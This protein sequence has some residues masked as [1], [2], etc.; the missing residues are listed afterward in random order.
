MNIKTERPQLSMGTLASLSGDFF[1][2]PEVVIGRL[3]RWGYEVVSQEVD[4][5]G[6]VHIQFC[7][8]E[9]LANTPL[10]QRKQIW[11]GND[12][13]DYPDKAS[14][15]RANSLMYIGKDGHDYAT[16]EALREANETYI[17]THFPKASRDKE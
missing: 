9:K 10:D 12:D 6:Y 5:N 7:E 11:L 2:K 8:G 13:R 16:I 3:N 4:K 1:P 14:R 17:Q 15:D